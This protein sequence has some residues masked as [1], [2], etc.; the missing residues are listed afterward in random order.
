MGDFRLHIKNVYK[1]ENEILEQR[2]ATGLSAM[3]SAD[4]NVQALFHG[5]SLKAAHSIIATGFQLPQ[6]GGMFGA[7]VYFAKTPLKSWQYS[8]HKGSA[9]L[10]VSDVALGLSKPARKGKNV[11][12]RVDL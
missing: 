2:F 12:P 4:T 11:D 5:T 6:T 10:L 9:Y 1:I 7:G 3:H 8:L